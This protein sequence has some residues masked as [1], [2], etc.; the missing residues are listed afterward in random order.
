[1][2]AA[3]Q[4]SRNQGLDEASLGN[5]LRGKIPGFDGP[6]AVKQ[7]EGGH[8]NP[9][10]RIITCA[11]DYVLR[12]RPA[13][14]LLPS[15]HLIEREFAIMQALWGIIPVPRMLHLCEDARII[16]QSFYVMEHVTGRLLAE[17]RMPDIDPAE[18]RALYLELVTVLARL[19]VADHRALGLEW[20]GRPTGYVSRQLA[21][22]SKQYA[23]ARIE[24]N[25]D[26]ERLIPWLE[27]NLPVGDE[28]AIVHGD[29]R[30]YNILFD[31]SSPRIAAVLDWE[32]ATIGHPVADLAYFCLPYYLPSDDLR[33]FRGEN[34]YDLAIPLEDEVKAVYCRETCRTDLPHWTYFLVFSMFRSAA[35]RA[36]VLKRGHD[37]TA[38]NDNALDAGRRYR[39]VAARAWQLVQSGR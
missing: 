36:G 39:G 13:G 31:Q 15:A 6:V 25:A 1:M 10:Y 5:H 16:G 33:G 17:A 9:T 12:K 11:G 4:V 20:F 29:Y 21:R 28:T 30:S 23:A 38:A 18:R 3:T 2:T 24:E 7:Y 19:H 35:I 26:M 37:G 32:L 8:S 34:P 14:D 22:W 27:R